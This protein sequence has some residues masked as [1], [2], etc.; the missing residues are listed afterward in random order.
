MAGTASHGPNG[1]ERPVR[2]RDARMDARSDRWS[3]V[4][5]AG[6]GPAKRGRKRGEVGSYLGGFGGARS[7]LSGEAIVI[8]RCGGGIFM[9]RSFDRNG[10][11]RRISRIVL[12]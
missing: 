11:S 5:D 12:P 7:L 8:V 4:M 2:G 6:G 10:D 1:P 3:G 9:F